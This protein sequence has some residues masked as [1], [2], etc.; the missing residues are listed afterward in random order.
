MEK[1]FKKNPTIHAKNGD[2]AMPEKNWEKYN[3]F[4]LKPT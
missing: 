2:S 4:V 3:I 1:L